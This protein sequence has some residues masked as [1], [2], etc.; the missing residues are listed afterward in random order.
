M[1]VYSI[2]DLEK[3]SGIKAHT[4]RIWEQRYRLITPKRT[5]TNIRYY[6][7]SDLKFLLSIALLNGNGV[8]IS[9]IADMT[10]HEVLRQVASISEV[11]FEH[12][13]ELDALTLSMIELD[14]YKFDRILTNHIQ[15]IGFERV[16]LE[17]IYPFLEKLSVLWL[18][19]SIALVQE[20]F[21]SN[22]IRQKIIVA[23]DKIPVTNSRAAKKF[24]LFLPEGETQELSMLFIHFLL[25]LRGHQ[26]LYVGQSASLSHLADAYRIY[27]ADY[28]FTMVTETFARQSL[29]T[30]L[31]ELLHVLPDT[32][33]L[34]SGYQTVSQQI[35]DRPSLTVLRSLDHTIR[36][37][38]DLS[39]AKGMRNNSDLLAALRN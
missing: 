7:D 5:V 2:K 39:F 11:T 20:Q 34:L 36:F 18:T 9:K 30:Y 3:L 32:H 31:D 21:V 27:R 37:L 25:K 17:V 22:L 19:G 8:K 4:I 6:E 14:E 38:D 24:M 23:I 29:E 13:A 26:V 10:P 12:G 15:Q 1:A 28:V 16:M 33:V 35:A